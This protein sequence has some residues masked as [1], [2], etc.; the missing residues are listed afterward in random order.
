M[1]RSGV[2]GVVAAAHPGL[3]GLATGV[4]EG[5]PLSLAPLVGLPRLRA[6]TAYPGTL[7]DPLEIAR[8]DG[9]EFLELAPEEWCVLLYAGAV[10]RGLSAAA[11]EVRGERNTLEIMDLANEVLVLRNRPPTTR[12]TIETDL[13]P[14]G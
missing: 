10:P 9:L 5:G 8:R 14:V 1:N 13:G 4:R 12:T 3:G 6:L 2:P 7:A 11:I